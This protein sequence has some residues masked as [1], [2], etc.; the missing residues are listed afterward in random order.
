MATSP[1][2]YRGLPQG[3]S[4]LDAF[5]IPLRSHPNIGSTVE[6][7]RNAG[8]VRTD[9]LEKAAS[10]VQDCFTAGLAHL[11]FR[12]QDPY[13]QQIGTIAWEAIDQS[14]AFP[15][16]TH[17]MRETAIYLGVHPSMIPEGSNGNKEA[18]VLYIG[19]RRGTEKFGFQYVLMPPEYAVQAQKNP[20]E[21]LATTAWVCSQ[22]RDAAN[23][24]YRLDTD[25]VIPRA[26]ATKAHFLYEARRRHPE[27]QLSKESRFLIFKYPLGINSLPQNALYR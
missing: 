18:Q 16:F 5:S 26:Y 20:I 8:V 24:R 9:D 6:A 27:A 13:I 7:I 25:W 21:A 4:I 10:A 2:S 3:D 23:D 12:E 15:V 22:L 14:Q 11:A 19:K 1:E 17:N